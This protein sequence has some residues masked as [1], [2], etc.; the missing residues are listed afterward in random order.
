[1]IGLH[2]LYPAV[3]AGTIFV[4][5][6]WQYRECRRRRAFERAAMID[7]QAIRDVAERA[8]SESAS[9]AAVIDR[10]PHTA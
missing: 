5:G 7:R 10:F 9:C 2:N 1:M 3:L 4:I 6:H 8:A